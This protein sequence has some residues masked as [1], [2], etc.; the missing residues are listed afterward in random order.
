MELDG[1]CE[2]LNLAFEYNGIQHYKKHRW[3][4]SSNDSFMQRR[5]DDNLKRVLCLDNNVKLIT[6]PYAVPHKK[7]RTY[8]LNS[9]EGNGVQLPTDA[10]T[11]EIDLLRAY[12]RRKI[13]FM[14]E[15]AQRHGG[16]C[17]SSYYVNAHTKLEWE[18]AKGHRWWAKPN[19]VQQGSWCSH[20]SGK[21]DRTLQDLK[22]LAEQRGGRCLS[23]LYKGTSSIYEWQCKNGHRWKASAI[24]VLYGKTWCP[25]CAKRVPLGVQQLQAYAAKKGGR[26]FAEHY[27]NSKQK[28]LWQCAEGHLWQATANSILRGSWCP[29]CAN[30]KRSKKYLG[31]AVEATKRA[32]Q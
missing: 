30:I 15:L 25:F 3:F 29:S 11:R 19:T 23:P 16:K 6:I 13:N 14:Q 20:C 9:C 4:H 24:N 7:L 10:Y 18:C 27:V 31:R 5:E 17:L 8:I 22:M 32:F 2:D 26:C 28:V 12:E 1:Y 21:E